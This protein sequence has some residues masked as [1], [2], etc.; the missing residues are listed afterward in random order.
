MHADGQTIALPCSKAECDFGRNH[1]HAPATMKAQKHAPNLGA[2][3]RERNWRLPIV[4]NGELVFSSV[5]S[6]ARSHSCLPH[7]PLLPHHDVASGCSSSAVADGAFDVVRA[8]KRAATDNMPVP[9]T[10]LCCWCDCEVPTS[11]L[12]TL[13][14]HIQQCCKTGPVAHATMRHD[15]SIAAS[16]TANGA[17]F[18]YTQSRLFMLPPFYRE[19]AG[20]PLAAYRQYALYDS[21]HGRQLVIL[22]EVCFRFLHQCGAF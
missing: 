12:D 9:K 2:L 4:V 15:S 6:H 18:Q 3:L 11:P 21:A 5:L 22:T 17:P 20:Q 14:R 16:A 19:L 8:L 10:I 1:Y 13:A 7:S